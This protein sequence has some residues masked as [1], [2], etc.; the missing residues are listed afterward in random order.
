MFGVGQHELPGDFPSALEEV[1]GETID[2]NL[3]GHK[4]TRV[5]TRRAVPRLVTQS[6]EEKIVDSRMQVFCQPNGRGHAVAQ[7]GHDLISIVQA[8]ANFRSVE[9]A[10]TVFGKGLFFDRLHG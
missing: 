9:S 10:V 6:Y 4:F 7:L 3:D 5:R 1:I 8:I 2:I